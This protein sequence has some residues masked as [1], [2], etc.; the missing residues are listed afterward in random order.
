MTSPV[1]GFTYPA[2]RT[3]A[4][5]DA[6]TTPRLRGDMTNL[7]NL[8]AG[9][10]RPML[11]SV[12]LQS[13]IPVAATATLLYIGN[14]VPLNTW[15][16]PVITTGGQAYYQVPFAGYYLAQG[17]VSYDTSGSPG[18][19]RYSMGFAT[20]V[21]GGASADSYGGSV[22][23]STSTS[24]PAGAGGCEL[25]Q[26][27]TY[28]NTADTLAMYAYTSNTSPGAV[29]IALLSLEWVGLPTSGL[30]SYTGPYGTV[31][32]SPK[33]AA[34]FPPGQGTTITNSGGISVGATSLTVSNPAGMITGGALGLD[35]LNGLLYQPYAEKVT[36]TS[37]S[38]STIGISATSYA[39]LQGAPVAVPVSYEFL[40]QQCRDIVNFQSYPPLLRAAVTTTQ[41][42]PSSTFPN[43]TQ[44][45]N[46]SASIDTFSGFGSN[47][48]TVPVAGVYFVYGQVFYTGSTSAFAASAGLS[49]SGGT[50]N[51]GTQFR[52]DTTSGV[53]SMCATVRRHLRLTAGQTVALYG[54]QNSGSAMTT[55]DTAGSYSRLICVWR[56]V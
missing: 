12:N 1:P 22:P 48:Y 32:S 8:F 55:I 54:T 3:W 24:E 30:T 5:G 44:I 18:Q 17:I 6:V 11:L 14:I 4:A 21:N 19:N 2:P 16:V 39:H 51:W 25:Y 28:A 42:I 35:Y 31:V 29:L 13:Q 52:S 41:S 23:A 20:V 10:A 53:Q 37:V 38:G 26:F 45:T 33:A 9:G 15:N 40:N 50:I 27:N 34:A 43:G 49:V 36:I 7:A 47:V 46:L 56:S